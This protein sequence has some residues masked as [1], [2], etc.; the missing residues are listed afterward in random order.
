MFVFEARSH[1]VALAGLE[2]AVYTSVGSQRSAHLYAPLLE[3]K[4][5][6][7]VSKTQ[8]LVSKYSKKI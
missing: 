8:F 4:D 3:L 5:F 7:T 6:T 1:Y 2:L